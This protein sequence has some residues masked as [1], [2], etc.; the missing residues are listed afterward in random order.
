MKRL[1]TKYISHQ[2]A[3]RSGAVFAIDLG[4]TNIR[5]AL[6]DDEGNIRFRF[7]GTTGRSASQDGIVRTIIEALRSSEEGSNGLRASALSVGVPGTV[8]IEKGIVVTAPNL[9]SLN[10]FHLAAALEREI[11]IPVLLENDANAAVVGEAWQ[12]A[13]RGCHFIVCA[14]L[15]TGVGGGI[16]LDD[17]LLRGAN[18][19]AAEIGH[20]AVDPFTGVACSCGGRGCLE[21]YA[22]APAVVRMTRERLPR[23]PNSP[24]HQVED[25]TAERIYCAGVRGD[26]L[27]LEIFRQLGIYLGIG[28]ANL[29]N[30]LNPDI[31]VLAGGLVNAWD[32]FENHMRQE[33]AERGFPSVAAQVPIVQAELGDDAGL[34]GA[35]RLAF[36]LFETA[37]TQAASLQFER[38]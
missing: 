30:I 17:R 24:L 10:G 4:G 18:G 38:H 11:K 21:V 3:H 15:G 29:I 19:S 23:Y 20:M 12:G 13:A 5:A 34:I 25:L 35:A 2:L 36:T 16:I 31:I 26:E 9:P 7:K 27:S 32:L 1:D 28:L 33:I 6:V 8:N 22:S 14:T 37:A